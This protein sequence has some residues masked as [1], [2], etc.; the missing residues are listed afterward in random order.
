MFSSAESQALL[1]VH[2]GQTVEILRSL[3]CPQRVV[4]VIRMSQLP[5]M[6][7]QG[8]IGLVARIVAVVAAYEALTA[9]ARP[10]REPLSPKD[11]VAEITGEAGRRFAPDVVAAFADLASESRLGEFALG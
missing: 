4:D 1:D 5:W 11:A 8:D 2:V 10:E 6:E 7:V 9:R 3:D